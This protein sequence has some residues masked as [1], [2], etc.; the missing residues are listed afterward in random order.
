[1]SKAALAQFRPA[2]AAI[3]R[4][5][6]I[7]SVEALREVVREAERSRALVI[8]TFASQELRQAMEQACQD[9][10][11]PSHDLLG[12]LL[13]KL[14]EFLGAP[15]GTTTTRRPSAS[16]RPTSFSSACR[17]PR[18]LRSASASPRRG[19]RSPTSRSSW[20]KSCPR[21]CFRSSSPASSDS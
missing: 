17:A 19:G 5:S 20:A 1:M 13:E 11:I 9:R 7:R 21:S 2:N 14:Q 10:N 6:N 15:W 4:H 18:R 12:P 3:T 16:P 8:H